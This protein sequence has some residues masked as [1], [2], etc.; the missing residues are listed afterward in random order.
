MFGSTPG[1]APKGIKSQAPCL[2]HGQLQRPAP[3]A[4]GL[5][6]PVEVFGRRRAAPEFQ[7]PL[8]D[9]G[10]MLQGGRWPEG[11]QVWSCFGCTS[12]GLGTWEG[13]AGQHPNAVEGPWGGWGRWGGCWVAAEEGRAAEPGEMVERRGEGR[14][15]QT[16]W[17][18]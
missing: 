18:V 5:T 11:A 2:R 14:Q 12:E 15:E 16:L 8:M 6:L 1:S 10:V 3:G 17:G 9:L 13:C 4:A 7:Q